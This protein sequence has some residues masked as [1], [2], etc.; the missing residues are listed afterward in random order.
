MSNDQV[1][2]GSKDQEPR[3]V[4]CTAL[5]EAVCEREPLEESEGSLIDLH[6][7]LG[8][9]ESKLWKSKDEV[10][11]CYHDLGCGS[12]LWETL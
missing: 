4:V 7:H 2:L 1:G 5:G 3:S 8:Y 9:L 11:R 10:I 12:D 6:E